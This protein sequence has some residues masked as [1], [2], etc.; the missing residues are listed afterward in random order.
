MIRAPAAEVLAREQERLLACVHCGF[1]LTACPTYTRLGDENDSPRG[2]LHLMRS[3]VEGRLDAAD[4]A[5]R[6]HID[7]CLGCRACEPVCPSGVQYGFLLERARAASARAAGTCLLSRALLF[8]MAKRSLTQLFSMLGI[9]LRATGLAHVLARALPARWSAIRLPFAMLAATQ[10]WPAL[11]TARA[12]RRAESIGAPGP[13]QVVAP[14]IGQNREVAEPHARAAGLRQGTSVNGQSNALP[15]AGPRG[16][17][18]RVAILEGC[19]QN[20]VYRRVNDA[21]VRVLRFN[22]CTVLPAQEQGCCGALHAH[23][24]QLDTAHRLARANIRAFEASG[25]DTIVVNAAGCGAIM[26]EYREH[27]ERDPAMKERAARFS[28]RVRDVSEF[29]AQLGV[30]RGAPIALRVTCDAPCHLMHAQR[31]A[32]APIDLLAAVPALEIVPLPGAEDC[33]GGAGI[34]GLQHPALGARILEDK[35]NAIRDTGAEA[36]L[37]PNPGCMMQIGAGFVMRGMDVPVLHPIEV[38][39]ESYRRRLEF[40]P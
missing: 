23:A 30:R 22:G 35:L 5:F 40:A 34:Y 31:I 24:G 10:P 15:V 29:L 39:D 28:S 16:A 21:T 25:A 9:A 1:C 8:V 12:H 26:K 33:C 2:R 7:R 17:A 11:R 4:A 37:T 32:T 27:F 36:V 6:T 13:E 19:I 38:L 3:V 20:G 14:T 18:P